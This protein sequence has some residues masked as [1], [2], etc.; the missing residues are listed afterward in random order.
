MVK[1]GLQDDPAAGRGQSSPTAR[2]FL[3]RRGQGRSHSGA[4]RRG[5]DSRRIL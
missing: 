2:L 4:A 5:R 3:D 1:D